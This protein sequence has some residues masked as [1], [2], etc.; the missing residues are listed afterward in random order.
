MAGQ[1][2][3]ILLKPPDVRPDEHS[4]SGEQSGQQASSG[5]EGEQKAGHKQRAAGG[6][7]EQGVWGE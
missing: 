3:S 5:E 6:L 7:G 2:A 1:V 4:T